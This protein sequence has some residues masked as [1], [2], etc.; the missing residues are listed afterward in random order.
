MGAQHRVDGGERVFERALHEDLAQ[1][2]R[3]QDLAPARDG[4]DARALAGG[5]LGEVQRAQ[6]ARFAVDEGQHPLLVEGVVAQGQAVGPGVK[7][8]ARVFGRQPRAGGRVFAVHHDEIEAPVGPQRLK[9]PGHRRASR[10]AHH[11]AQK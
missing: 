7:Q 10:T 5:K 2:L 11:I 3:D 1:R 8:K 4:E 6:D 9:P